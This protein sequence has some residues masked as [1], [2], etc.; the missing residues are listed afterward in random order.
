VKK[1]LIAVVCCFFLGSSLFA[2]VET[3]GLSPRDARSMGMGGAFR[4]F[5]TGYSTFFGNPAGFAGP[6]SFTI[7]DLATWGYLKPYPVN[8]AALIGIA[9]GQASQSSFESTIG[10]LMAQDNGF[11]GGFSLGMGWAGG[12]F[13]LGLTLIS[14]A[15]TSDTAYSGS[16]VESKNQANAVLGM[17]WPLE[18]GKISLRFGADIRAFYRLDS[19]GSWPFDK[20]ATAFYTGTGFVEELSALSARG[21]YGFAVDSGATLSWGPLSAGV[22]IRDYGYKFY[23]SDATIS[24]IIEVGSPPMSGDIL[25]ALTPQYSAG[26][27]LVLGKGGPIVY[28]FYA[29]VDDPMNFLTVAGSDFSASLD[30]LHAGYEFSVFKFLSLR[31]GVNQGLIAMGIGMDFSLLEVDAALFTEPLSSS[32]TRTGVTIQAA[33]RI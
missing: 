27:S 2:Q 9:E 30:L 31:G 14:D 7:A 3:T 23:M 28:S 32:A 13:G 5:S 33:L 25:Y 22:M 19:H 1:F 17:A 24:D 20:L 6:K 11:G 18:L 15:Q 21:G 29:E 8:I 12:G 26:L 4:V 10:S 16:T